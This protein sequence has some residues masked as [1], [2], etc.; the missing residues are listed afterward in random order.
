MDVY[1]NGD[2]CDGGGVV[3]AG[4]RIRC[5][6]DGGSFYPKDSVAFEI[7]KVYHVIA[8]GRALAIRVTQLLYESSRRRSEVRFVTLGS[9]DRHPPGA[10][11]AEPNALAGTL[12]PSASGSG[13][14]IQPLQPPEP[15]PGPY[16]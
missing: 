5:A 15:A 9:A 16:S 11:P 13:T 14:D 12:R 3:R 2:I 6:A 8:E 7:G 10:R 4:L 1:F